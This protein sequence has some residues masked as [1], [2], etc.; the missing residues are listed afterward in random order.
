M[1]SALVALLFGAVTATAESLRIT[2]GEW[3][4]YLGAE[5]PHYG[6]AS[7]IVSAAFA[8]SGIKVRYGFFPWSRALQLARNGHWDGSAVWLASPEREADFHLSDP[9]VEARY[10]FFHLREQAFDW[11]EI[12]D[13]AGLRVGGTLAY[14]YGESFQA[15]ERD[16]LIKV[17]R[18]SSDEQ[19]F[20]RLLARR[21]QVFPMDVEVG[22]AMLKK[23]FAPGE[24]AR[25]TWHPLPLRTDPLRLLLTRKDAANA[26]R[27]QRF[28]EGL[29]QVRAHGNIE[30][31]LEE[32]RNAPPGPH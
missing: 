6:V 7:R 31:W 22:H 26:E 23:Y 13:L 1:L 10:V 11:K 18:V 17:E 19:N 2:N 12:D 3:P 16:G 8:Q 14:D 30:R 24:Q 21:I 15:A 29:R 9:V 28:N 25:V 4:P 27:M 5:L 20:A 32:A